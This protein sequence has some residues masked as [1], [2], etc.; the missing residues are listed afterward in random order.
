MTIKLN[1]VREWKLAERIDKGG[2]GQVFAALSSDGEPAV[3]KLVPK[4]PRADRELL[5]VELNGVRNVIPIIDKGD[6]SDNWAI[7]MPRAE[8]SLRKY[9]N[10]AGGP[11]NVADCVTILCDIVVALVDLD[12]KVV[13]RDLKPENI[14]YLNGLLHSS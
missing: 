10:E 13:H 8:K 7:V 3:V 1:L 12:G 5:F 9:L 4:A 6:A 11:L 2:F 14:L